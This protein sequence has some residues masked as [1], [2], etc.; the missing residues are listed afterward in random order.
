FGT[1]TTTFD[2][3][4]EKLTRRGTP[5]Q[6][7]YSPGGGRAKFDVN[8]QSVAVTEAADILKGEVTPKEIV[9]KPG[10]EGKLDVPIQRR[11]DYDKGV[12][13]DILLRHL[14]TVYGNTLPPG[15]TI[16]EG[17]SKT[18]LGTGSKGHIVLKA[19][20][21]AAPIEGVPISV[22]AHVSVNFVVKVSYS[23]PPIPV[24]VRK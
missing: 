13:L 8:L 6:E 4:E 11:A 9:L 16:V 20:A 24:S 7:I 22:L 10:E 5:S 2:G 17:K 1:A 21:D 18:L 15:V 12:S 19:A 14:N 23:S 3:K